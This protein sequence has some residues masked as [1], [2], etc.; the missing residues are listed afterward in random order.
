MNFLAMAGFEANEVIAAMPGVLDLAAAGQMDLARTS[1]ISSNILSGFRLEASEM[2]RVSDVLAATM[3]SANTNIEQLG[4][5]MSYAAPVAADMGVSIEEASAAI[6]R[7]S[8]AGIQGERAGTSLRAILMA[9]AAPTDVAREQMDALGVQVTDTAGEF[10]SLPDIIA[11]FEERLAGMTTAQRTAALGTIF[12]NRQIGA[13]N[14]LLGVGSE[15]LR[16]YTTE[17]ENAGGT[18]SRLAGD[19]MSTFQGTLTELG[20]SL[21]G[22]GI[23]VG[24]ELLPV[25]TELVREVFIPFTRLYGPAMVQLAGG[26]ANGLRLILRE[27]EPLI[28]YMQ[29]AGAPALETFIALLRDGTEGAVDAAVAAYRR[30]AEAILEQ[31]EGWESSTAALEVYNQASEETQRQLQAEAQAIE[32]QRE[33]L[34]GYIAM[35]QHR[36]T[37]GEITRDQ[38]LEELEALN[39]QIE[40]LDK[41]APRLADQAV[42]LEAAGGAS[43]E[44]VDA[45]SQLAQATRLTKDEIAALDEELRK[46]EQEG[47][48]AFQDAVQTEVGFLEDREEARRSH[49][50]RL[51][52]IVRDG[53]E[54]RESIQ[55]DIADAE[56]R[57]AEDTA[58]NQVRMAEELAEATTEAER[59]AAYERHNERQAD[60]DQRIIQAREANV[61]EL[62]DL[63]T[64]NQERLAAQQAAFEEQERQAA[65]SYA[66]QQAQQLAHLGQELINYVTVKARQNGVSDEALEEMTA[67]I[68]GEFG[69]QQS[70]MDR[71]YSD[72][73]AMADSWAENNGENTDAYIGQMRDVRSSATETQREVNARIDQLTRE[74]TEAFHRGELGPDAY[75][76]RLSEI[77]GEAEAAVGATNEQLNQLPAELE[78]DYEVQSTAPEDVA[79]INTELDTI[80]REVETVHRVKREAEQTKQDFVASLASKPQ[81][82]ATG[83]VMLAGR[84]Y[85]TGEGGREIVIPR[86]DSTILPNAVSE[87]LLAS[88]SMP[89]SAAMAGGG[90]GA[91]IQM[92]GVNI[93]INGA[94]VDNA[95][96]LQELAATIRAEV[97]AG[98]WQ[99]MSRALDSITIQEVW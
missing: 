84:A 92:G 71:S 19:M 58:E 55:E 46:I 68:R 50:E 40:A 8:D 14:V 99:Q 11:Q 20:S 96:R 21:E 82:M 73:M 62:Q 91:T 70:L 33:R 45:L 32:A 65:E 57:F 69:V 43:E 34:V 59:Q 26:F 64:A 30:Q 5:A 95:S 17:L 67:G 10:Y 93:T 61:E 80:P 24:E 72:F 85:E 51:A 13:F 4:F 2:G 7:L 35:L 25:L 98:T 37:T 23:E 28:S 1:D 75:A 90:G 16:D 79:A 77:P 88:A 49:E 12:G 18:A 60:I 86:V 27:L 15:E 36:Y 41:M 22:L 89:T 78:T 38:Y 52:G 81:G 83:G 48:R 56:A 31:Q 42:A 44:A 97:E 94:T 87:R 6:G 9:L 66:R 53:E 3:T 74:A 29:V 39:A 76:T 63:E 47:L 54:R